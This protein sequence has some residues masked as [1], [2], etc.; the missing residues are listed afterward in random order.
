MT[1]RDFHI[2]RY[3]PKRDDKPLVQK[4]APHSIDNGLPPERERLQSPTACSAA[5]RIMNCTDAR[6]KGL[7]PGKAIGEI[8]QLMMARRGA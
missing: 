6:P 5:A 3:D 8:K 7:N 1:T 2:D 4:V